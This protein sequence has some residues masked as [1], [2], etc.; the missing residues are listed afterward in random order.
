MYVLVMQWAKH[1]HAPYYLS[2]ISF[3]E[4][5]FWPIPVDV[6]LAPMA[7]GKPQK[8]WFYASLATVFSVLGALLGYLIG[9]A[10]WDPVVQPLVATMGYDGKI[11]EAK[12]WFEHWE[13][14]VI[15]IAS[16]T[17]IPYKVFTVTAGLLQIALL[18]FVVVSLFGRGLRFFMV[19]GLM[20]WGGEKMERKL[21]HYVDVLGWIC[22]GLA[23][24]A[25][26]WF[27][28]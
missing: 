26:F 22:V 28:R 8:A 25:Y 6:M 12:Q 13:V 9:Y 15:F 11:F 1:R 10:L 3:I 19:A 7:L 16:F 20:R 23:V 24:A 2:F 5:V 14:W 4:S 27:S 17:P 18:P 21:M